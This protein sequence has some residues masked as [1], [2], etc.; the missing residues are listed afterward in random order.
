MQAFWIWI[1]INPDIC[2]HLQVT[3][4][5]CSFFA[6][7]TDLLGAPTYPAVVVDFVQAAL[8]TPAGMA[9]LPRVTFLLNCHR[10]GASA[11]GWD[12]DE[13]EAEFKDAFS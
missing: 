6:S 5:L 3:S 8:A 10:F 1:R 4:P 7:L 2:T 12:R 9:G 11:V 13:I